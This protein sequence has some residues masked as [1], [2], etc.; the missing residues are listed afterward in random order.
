[1]LLDGPPRLQG[2][3]CNGETR[4][5]S[6]GQIL[7]AS[8]TEMLLQQKHAGE[9]RGADD[10]LGKLP[11]GG[12]ARFLRQQMMTRAINSIRRHSLKRINAISPFGTVFIYLY[13]RGNSEFDHFGGVLPRARDGRKEKT[14]HLVAY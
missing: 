1:M 14:T 6:V 2:E 12:S 4:L 3:A 11:D 9:Q 5:G 13:T 7:E 8:F 10:D